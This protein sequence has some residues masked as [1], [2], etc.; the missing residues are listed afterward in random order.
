MSDDTTYQARMT[1]ATGDTVEVFAANETGTMPAFFMFLFCS[2]SDF[3]A[4]VDDSTIIF[5]VEIAYF[6]VF[7]AGFLV[8]FEVFGSQKTLITVF[9]G[10]R[11]TRVLGCRLGA[12]SRIHSINRLRKLFDICQDGRIF[13]LL[14]LLRKIGL[15]EG[16]SDRVTVRSR[17]PIGAERCVLFT[18]V[19]RRT[20]LRVSSNLGSVHLETEFPIRSKINR[21]GR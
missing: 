3:F 7:M 2:N 21:A 16:V 8:T 15:L 4:M 14:E 19:A 13:Q 9:E 12:G 10:T 18:S 6:T 17:M 5:E 1:R 20:Y 11:K